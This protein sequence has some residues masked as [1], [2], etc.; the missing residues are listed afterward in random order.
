MG[1]RI[2]K[3]LGYALTDFEYDR[4]NWEATDP[5]VNTALIN[6]ED[7]IYDLVANFCKWA[8]SDPEEAE[9][10]MVDEMGLSSTDAMLGR[11]SLSEMEGKRANPFHDVLT[12]APE[13]GLPNVLLFQPLTNKDWSRYGDTIDLYEASF[14]DL[15]DR[16]ETKVLDFL[17][18][19]VSGIYPYDGFMHR[20]PDRDTPSRFLK[21]DEELTDGDLE[22]QETSSTGIRQGVLR[23]R[24]YLVM[25]QAKVIETSKDP[26]NTKD[27]QEHLKNDWGCRIPPQILLFAH[28]SNI[29]TDFNTVYRLRP[30]LYTYWT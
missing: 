10:Y 13:F 23:D 28:W 2:T 1:I 27:F 19:G 4:D 15:E 3:R 20:Y 25:M 21:P 29:F 12:L 8:L 16:Y 24:I 5:R 30:V 9:R 11:M 26:E 18:E 22:R 17:D 6:E 7:G 14:V